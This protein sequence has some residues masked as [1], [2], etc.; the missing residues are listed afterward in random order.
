MR[1]QFLSLPPNLNLAIE[2]YHR[3]IDAFDH[4]ELTHTADKKDK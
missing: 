4:A 3:A 1:Y 2:A